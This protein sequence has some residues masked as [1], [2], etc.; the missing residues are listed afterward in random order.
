MLI[1]LFPLAEY[2]RMRKVI[3][4]LTTFCK[5]QNFQWVDKTNSFVLQVNVFILK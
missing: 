1:N 3:F 2:L 5:M 4:L